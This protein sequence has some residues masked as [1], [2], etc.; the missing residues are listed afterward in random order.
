VAGCGTLDGSVYGII[1]PDNWTVSAVVCGWPC[2]PYSMLVVCPFAVGCRSGFCPSAWMLY[3]LLLQT[4][5]RWSQCCCPFLLNLA[6]ARPPHTTMQGAIR[7][8]RRLTLLTPGT[9]PKHGDGNLGQ[10]LREHL[11]QGSEAP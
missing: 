4:P 7:L 6:P 1:R 10:C 11:L 5:R 9:N 8:W 3:G 2:L